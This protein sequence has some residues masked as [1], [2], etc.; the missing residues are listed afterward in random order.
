MSKKKVSATDMQKMMSR[1]KSKSAKAKRPAAKSTTEDLIALKKIKLLQSGEVGKSKKSTTTARSNI[2]SKINLNAD[3]MHTS[4][5]KVA[6]VAAETGITASFFDKEEDRIA[7]KDLF[8]KPKDVAPVPN[9]LMEVE[10]EADDK[11]RINKR[12]LIQT[13]DGA[14]VKG[15]GI[16]KNL[17][18]GFYDDKTK[19]ANIRG[20]ETP[21]DKAKREWN[22]FTMA[23]NE[24][25]VKS[26]QMLEEEDESFNFSKDIDEVDQQI[27]MFTKT[28]SLAD[29]VKDLRKKRE[30]LRKKK[31]EAAQDEEMS[32]G[33]EDE[34]D[35]RQQNIF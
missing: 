3:Q 6:K 21:A 27:A 24:E 12:L 11:E 9:E 30:E 35:W 23:M 34:V 26:N 25:T 32:S 31:Q 2:A 10:Q 15:V 18:Q 33:S 14:R 19:D 16:A 4:A 20:V 1:L 5:K 29:R 8:N 22:E 28:K 17:P 13:K 7:N